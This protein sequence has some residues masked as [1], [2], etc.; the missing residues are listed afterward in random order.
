MSFFRTWAS[1]RPDRHL[2]PR[3]TAV[4]GATVIALVAVGVAVTTSVS[5]GGSDG[6]DPHASTAAAVAPRTYV[7]LG[8]SFTSGPAIPT[9]LG[10]TTSPSAPS[11][12]QRSSEN[13]PTLTAQVLG[14]TL[15]DVSCGGATTADL[16]GSQGTGIP[17]QLDALRRSTSLVTV[18]I[19]GNDLG[20]S[21]IATSCA[22][23]TPW[24][25]TQV[26]WSCRAHYTSGG[27]DQLAAAAQQ[28]G[29]KVASVLRDVRER[30]PHARV[31]VIGYPDIVPQTG[32]GCWPSLPFTA[33]DLS[34]LRGVETNL[35]QILESEARAAG[36][37][38]VDMATPSALH[39]ACSPVA[40]RWVEPVLHPEGSFPLHPGATGMAGMAGVLVGAVRSEDP[41]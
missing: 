37:G 5:A 3:S 7:A 14:L 41:R 13:Y 1:S 30:A 9:Q 19:G 38:Y 40:F 12:C 33:D 11:A 28:V 34:Y 22:A 2:S 27:T 31:L 25:P 21:T 32:S 17:P 10:P 36:D 15:T 35:N 24:G 39:D 8:D 23:Y 18:G 29:A 20:F 16:T 4:L 26:G 6:A